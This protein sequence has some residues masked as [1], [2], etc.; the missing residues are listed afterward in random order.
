MSE[1]ASVDYRH[2]DTGISGLMAAAAYG[3]LPIVKQ[4]VDLGNFFNFILLINKK[5]NI[6]VFEKFNE[7]WEEGLC[8]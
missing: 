6:F 3:Y 8:T 7:V 5:I 4:F 2:R 1:N